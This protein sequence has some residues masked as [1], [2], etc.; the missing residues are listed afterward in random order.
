MLLMTWLL[1][2][3]PDCPGQ[4]GAVFAGSAGS[5]GVLYDLA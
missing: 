2:P 3:V 1:R 4:V 5:F